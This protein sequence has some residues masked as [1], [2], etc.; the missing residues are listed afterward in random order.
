MAFLELKNVSKSYGSGNKRVQVL[1]NINLAVNEGEFL[2]I[3]GFSGSGKTTLIS[4]VAGLMEP[5]EG[6]ILLNGRSIN[7]PGPDRAVVFQN[8]SLLPWLTARQ[9]VALAVNHLFRDWDDETRAAHIDKYI[10]MVNLTD[11]VFKRPHELSGGMR[12]RVSVARTLAMNPEI[13]LLDEPLGALDALTRGTLQI[14]IERI[15]RLE[16]KTVI[17]ITNDIDEAILLADRIVPL[18]PGPKATLGPEFP[19]NLARPRDKKS[20]NENVYFKSLRNGITKHLIDVRT[21]HRRALAEAVA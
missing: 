4:L 7:G 17:L 16:K 5:D 10:R 8:Y 20:F 6:E 1:Q 21:G 2:A 9:N 11:A 12:Q 14:E 18:H 3:L 19:V 15:W 13:L